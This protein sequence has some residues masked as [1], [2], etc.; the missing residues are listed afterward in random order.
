MTGLPG[1]TVEIDQNPYLPAGGR[2][3]S[4]IVTVT[5][6]ETG[7]APRPTAAGRAARRRQR[8]DHH[9]RLLGVD[10][11]P[12]DQARRGP[13]GDRGRGGRDQGRDVVRDRRGHL[14]RLAGLPGGRVDGG[15]GRAH[16]GG[17]QG[18]AA[19]AAGQRRDRDRPVAAAGAPD[20]PVLP[21]DAAARHPAHRR[22]EPARD[23]GRARRRGQPVRGRVP[24]RLPGRRHRL[25][26]RRA[27]Q[28]LH[29]AA[30]QRSTSWWT[31]P[32]SRPTS[33]S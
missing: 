26:G 5:A 22:Q 30:R 14:H 28:D 21:G 7:D 4:A 20:L 32:G 17:G 19:P 9:R 2:D 15:R 31:R 3:V 23:P 27:A 6:D 29:R 24:L 8:G 25:G 18:G 33:R 12:A 1:F 11:L 13:R 10:G 16:P